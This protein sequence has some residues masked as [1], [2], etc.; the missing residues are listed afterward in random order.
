[1]QMTLCRTNIAFRMLL[2]MLVTFLLASPLAVAPVQG[3]TKAGAAEPSPTANR[4]QKGLIIPVEQGIERGLEAFLARAFREAQARGAD[5]VILDIDT[6]G[7]VIDAATN[8]GLL[9][10]Q[11]PMHVV[12]Y[13]DNQA[14]S[15]GTYIA[16]NADEIVMT[17]GSAIGAATPIDMTGNAADA[18]VI[19]AWSEMMQ[20]AALLNN[21]DRQIARA[22]V[23][24]DLV[25]PNLKERGKVLSLGAEKAAEVGY[26]DK[27]VANQ[28]ELFQYLGINP[29]QVVQLEPTLSERLARFVTNPYVMSFLLLTGLLGFIVE[30]FVPGFG[31][32]GTVGL[33]SFALY[34]FGHYV[35]GF[36]DWLHIALFVL[37]VVLMLAEIFLPGG[38]VGI[39][40][41]ASLAASLVLA[42]YDTGQG[43]VSLGFAALLT[44]I[45]AVVLAKRY[46]LK[47]LIGKFVL[48]DELRSGHG[49]IAPP[50]QREL[51]GQGGIAL[52]PLRPSGIIKIGGRRIDAVSAGD[53][54]AAGTE[55]VVIQVE[56][57]RVVVEEKENKIK[58]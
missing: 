9:V 25:I 1:V 12:A 55:V 37:G 39:L 10:R 16:L 5:L 46:G 18:K 15:A 36:A 56:G 7:G 8:I 26:A 28:A 30:L 4:F 48:Q 11:A 2:T 43:L 6:P 40:G 44:A 19:S 22:M 47:G 14:F 23:E 58:E 52:T 20:E 27:I 3:E 38:I 13:I 31:V 51:A 57:S 17:P 35:A 24:I 21:R 49:Y 54:I 45:V 33:L 41:F 32:G 29:D 50:D 53:F 42:A 34:F